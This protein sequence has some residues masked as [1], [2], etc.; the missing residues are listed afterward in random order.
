M[1]AG[2]SKVG[3]LGSRVE[4]CG[5]SAGTQNIF[6]YP[7]RFSPTINRQMAS[8]WLRSKGANERRFGLVLGLAIALSVMAIVAIQIQIHQGRLGPSRIAATIIPKGSQVVVSSRPY[9]GVSSSSSRRCKNMNPSQQIDGDALSRT[10]IAAASGIVAAN[11]MEESGVQSRLE[12]MEKKIAQL[13][14]E[15][16]E[17]RAQLSAT[18]PTNSDH[19][20]HQRMDPLHSTRHPPYRRLTSILRIRARASIK[21]CTM[22]NEPLPRLRLRFNRRQLLPHHP[23]PPLLLPLLPSSSSSSRSYAPLHH[24][25]QCL[26]QHRRG[27]AT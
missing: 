4:I 11:G 3:V 10:Y 14:S 1:R 18:A 6:A 9:R 5:R 25:L 13:E 16:Y 7:L 27:A 21:L 26:L 2:R 20:Q 19:D 22:N 15:N 8:G 23:P 17:L 24:L 12:A